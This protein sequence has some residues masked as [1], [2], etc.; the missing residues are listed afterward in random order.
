[1]AEELGIT[2]DPHELTFLATLRRQTR[3]HSPPIR[4]NE[5]TDV[6]LVVR[7]LPIEVFR[8]QIEE[9]TAVAWVTVEELIR[10]V[11]RGDESLVPHPEEYRRLFAVLGR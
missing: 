6:Y 8:I 4:D 10:R 2:I 7:D 11:D 5:F 3:Y 9:L 1:V